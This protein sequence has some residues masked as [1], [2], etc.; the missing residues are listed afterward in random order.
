[1]ATVEQERQER[2]EVFAFLDGLGWQEWGLSPEDAA[3]LLDK[4]LTREVPVEVSVEVIAPPQVPEFASD[5]G[6][7]FYNYVIE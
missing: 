3:L 1:M 2:E 5:E 6:Q 4:L 7:A